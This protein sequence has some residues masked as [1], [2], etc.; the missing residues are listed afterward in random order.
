MKFSLLGFLQILAWAIIINYLKET[1][2]RGQ[3]NGKFILSNKPGP[4]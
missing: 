4:T 1:N 3:A 2:L